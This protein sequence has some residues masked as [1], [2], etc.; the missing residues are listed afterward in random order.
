MTKKFDVVKLQDENVRTEYQLELRNRFEQLRE[1]QDEIGWN[2]IRNVVKETAEAKIGYAKR[3]KKKWF[4]D[5]CER[6]AENRRS[7]RLSWLIDRRN[8][9]KREEFRRRRGEAK[10]VYKR[11]K[12]E[13]AQKN[14]RE[15]EENRRA[16]RTRDQYQGINNVKKG[17]QPR[18]M[19]VKDKEGRLLVNQEEVKERWK[20]YFSDLLNRPSPD[21]PIEELEPELMDQMDID[22][23]SEEEVRRAIKGM[24]NNKAAGV[25]GILAEMIKYGGGR[26]E[27]EM[28][29]LYKKIWRDEAMPQEW[30]EGI[31]LPL[32]K[33]DDRHS[34]ENYRGLCLLT[35]GYK[36]LANILCHRLQPHYL[37][38]VGEYQV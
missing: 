38:I 13:E 7:A 29:T 35:I 1:I 14:I 37:R 8:E 12:K 23:I 27:E 18:L 25:D 6:A 34:C 24:K 33:K 2:D 22:D 19:M 32:H 4:D 36:V 28:T 3:T 20:Q 26:M 17:Y 30:Q 10:T 11:K 5:D 21:H 15:I 16:K 9:M 31:Y